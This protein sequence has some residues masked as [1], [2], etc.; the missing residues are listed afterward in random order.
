MKLVNR[1]TKPRLFETESEWKIY[2]VSKMS[3]LGPGPS[4]TVALG[5]EVSRETCAVD[6]KV[7]KSVMHTAAR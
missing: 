1:L 2:G 7:P 4:W 3:E 5:I 6:V